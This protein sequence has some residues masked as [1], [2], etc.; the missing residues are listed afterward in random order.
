MIYKAIVLI[1]LWRTQTTYEH[2]DSTNFQT[3]I[4]MMS[5]HALKI[6]LLYIYAL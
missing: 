2:P 3:L 4:L 1:I 6:D 5:C